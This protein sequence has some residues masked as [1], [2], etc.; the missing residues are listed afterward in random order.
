M[1]HHFGSHSI[2]EERRIL[3]LNSC[4]PPGADFYL[5]AEGG[6]GREKE[7]ER[8]RISERRDRSIINTLCTW[9]FK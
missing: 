9:I 2:V 7:R 4:I 1:V 8:E 3:I 5:V 6:G